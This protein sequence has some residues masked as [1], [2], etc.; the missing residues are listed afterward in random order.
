[1]KIDA[2]AVA[3]GEVQ[4]QRVRRACQGAW[5]DDGR[6]PATEVR[7]QD[8]PQ[9]AVGQQRRPR[10]AETPAVRRIDDHQT[11]GRDGRARVA[12]VARGKGDVRP[13]V[14]AI[15]VAAG[16]LDGPRIAM[17]ESQD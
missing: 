11:G 16:A 12:H 10:V 8:A 1:M 15:G 14:G 4:A 9:I 5:D 7:A 6:A 17:R 2:Q 13:E 3:R